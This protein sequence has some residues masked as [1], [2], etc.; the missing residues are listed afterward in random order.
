MTNSDKD[1]IAIITGSARGIGLATAQ[2]MKANGLRPVLVD[3]DADALADA[4]EQL[5]DVLAIECDISQPDQIASMIDSVIS[6]YGQIDV[7]VNNAGIADFGL[8]RRYR[9]YPLARGDGHKS[10]RGVFM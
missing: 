10:G 6:G 3:Y 9:F 8:Y 7:L 1:K 2:K 4:K 5:G